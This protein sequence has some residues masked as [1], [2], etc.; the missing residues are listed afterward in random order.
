MKSEIILEANNS[1]MNCSEGAEEKTSKKY[2]N[3]DENDEKKRN[4]NERWII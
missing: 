2:Q 3:F 4:A 1:S